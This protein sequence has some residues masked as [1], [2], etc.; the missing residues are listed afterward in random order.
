MTPATPN[1]SPLGFHSYDP[2]I[3]AG[4]LLFWGVPY[5]IGSGKV[6]IDAG[7]AE[8]S[9]LGK[10]PPIVRLSDSDHRTRNAVEVLAAPRSPWQNPFAERLVGFIKTTNGVSVICGRTDY[11]T[12]ET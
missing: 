9:G 10:R 6:D 1:G 11:I 5:P 8:S 7:T 12:E 3:G 4:S 2:G